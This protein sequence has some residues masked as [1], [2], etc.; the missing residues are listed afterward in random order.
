MGNLTHGARL[1]V[2]KPTEID[3]QERT[4][5][6]RIGIRKGALDWESRYHLEVMARN[7]WRLHA[8]DAWLEQHGCLRPDGEPWPFM[9]DYGATDHRFSLAV[10]ALAESLSK[11]GQKRDQ[12]ALL[13]ELSKYRRP[14]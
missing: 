9:N 14:S 10:K 8:Y 2:R 3:R 11:R 5:A 6:N 4:L 7:R 13:D 1:K 12:A